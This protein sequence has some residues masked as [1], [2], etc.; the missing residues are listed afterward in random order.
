[1]H[2]EESILVYKRGVYFSTHGVHDLSIGLVG[3]GRWT[4]GEIKE[5]MTEKLGSGVGVGWE[6]G[7]R[8]GRE[9]RV[10]EWSRVLHQQIIAINY[11]QISH[12]QHNHTRIPF[13]FTKFTRFVSNN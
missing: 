13:C 3:W 12:A 7:E 2:V 9:G 5:Q 8:R 11:R 10:L 4:E 6:G 1:M